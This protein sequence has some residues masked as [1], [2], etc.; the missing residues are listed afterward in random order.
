MN[1]EQQPTSPIDQIIQQAMRSGTFAN[2]PGQGKPQRFDDDHVPE[3]LRMA[4]RMLREHEFAPPWIESL[5][6]IE[7]HRAAVDGW[8]A[9][10]NRRW[11]TL[12]EP[13][14]IA[15]RQELRGKLIELRSSI[16]THNLKLP[17]GIDHLPNI[18]LERELLRLGD[19]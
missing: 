19:T 8:L 4:F 7:Q 17:P 3:E 16:L 6:D 13:L 12:P 2:L 1:D 18:Q 11:R 5:K 14:R 10:T 15:A 9:D